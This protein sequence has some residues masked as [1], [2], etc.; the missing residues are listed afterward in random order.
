MPRRAHKNGA[1]PPS[2]PSTNSPQHQLKGHAHAH[3]PCSHTRNVMPPPSTRTHPSGSHHTTR[4][5]SRGV[6]FR[7]CPCLTFG[8]T[9]FPLTHVLPPFDTHATPL[10]FSRTETTQRGLAAEWRFALTPHRCSRRRMKLAGRSSYQQRAARTAPPHGHH[11]PRLHSN[12]YQLEDASA[13]AHG[14]AS[15]AWKEGCPHDQ[16]SWLDSRNSSE[17]RASRRV[18]P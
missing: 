1:F 12:C 15:C 2:N 13:S 4:C 16:E 3:A 9:H 5:D 6:L 11:R 8:C 7:N 18:V 14:R 17:D 10:H